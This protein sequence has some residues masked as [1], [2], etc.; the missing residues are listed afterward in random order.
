MKTTSNYIQLAGLLL[1]GLLCFAPMDAQS[2][3]SK[4][5]YMLASSKPESTQVK[6]KTATATPE[7]DEKKIVC[8][9][10]SVEMSPSA[11]KDQPEAVIHMYN[12]A[13][14]EVA[15]FN[16]HSSSLGDQSSK[17]DSNAD[18]ITLYYNIDMLPYFLDLLASGQKLEI[19][20]TSRSGD[21][22]VQTAIAAVRGGGALRQSGASKMK[23]YPLQR[24]GKTMEKKTT[25]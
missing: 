16:F 19:T 2:S 18:R 20:H 17:Y 23:Q 11:T 24:G 8:D 6:K 12:R 5:G 13:K 1:V 21:V 7:D 9:M 15:T 10:Y 3:N 14:E 22:T 25:K 4:T